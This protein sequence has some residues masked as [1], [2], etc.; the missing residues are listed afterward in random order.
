MKVAVTGGSGLLGTV[1]LRKLAADR[2][3]TGIVSLD[4]RPPVVASKKVTVVRADVT[5]PDFARHLEGCDALVHLAFIVVSWAPREVM[6]AINVEGSKNV[7]RAAAKAGI[8]TIVYTSSVA[9]YGVVDG[10]PKPIVEETPRVHQTRFAYAANKFEVEAFLDGFEKEHEDIAISR[11]RPAIVLGARVDNPLGRAFAA[12][13]LVDSGAPPMPYVWDEDVAAAALLC[14]KKRARGAFNVVADDPLAAAELARIGGLRHVR[15][16]FP[17]L[18]AV[19]RLQPVIQALGGKPL[20]DPAWVDEPLP[21][22][23]YSSEKAKRELGWAPKYPTT[24]DIMRRVGETAHG[25]TDPRLVVFMRLSALAAAR[26]PPQVD[27]FRGNV[28]LEVTGPGGGDWTLQVG[29]GMVLIKPGIPRPPT[30]V[31]S[32]K[33]STFLELLAG[34]QSSATLEFTGKMRVEGEPIGTMLLAGFSTM[35]KVAAEP[36]GPRGWPARRLMEWMARPS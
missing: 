4:L 24:A 2:S 5:D 34:R 35:L 16:P 26:M 23:V 33:A 15:V 19:G 1:V 3:I 30:S 27:T 9:A 20:F 11:L 14:L 32:L 18:H 6:Q 31:I 8:K 7:I 36:K 21:E 17:L 10:H 22:L 29:D 12:R 28:H 13:V 25:R